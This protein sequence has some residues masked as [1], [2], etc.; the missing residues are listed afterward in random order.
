MSPLLVAS[1]SVKTR[2]TWYDF[3]YEFWRHAYDVCATCVRCFARCS[4]DATSNRDKQQHLYDFVRVMFDS[5]TT[6]PRVLAS[7]LVLPKPDQ[8]LVVLSLKRSCRL[9][10][11]IVQ[12]EESHRGPSLLPSSQLQQKRTNFQG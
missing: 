1:R 12:A 10:P 8:Q 7:C 2:A 3:V 5:L 6:S 9:K 11:G 4:R